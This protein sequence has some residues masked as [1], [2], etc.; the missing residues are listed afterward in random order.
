MKRIIHI[1]KYLVSTI[2]TAD[3]FNSYDLR[4]RLFNSIKEAE[5]FIINSKNGTL[6]CKRDKL[7]FTTYENKEKKEQYTIWYDPVIE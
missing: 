5:K 4:P 2:V 7:G 1:K 6:V 3:P